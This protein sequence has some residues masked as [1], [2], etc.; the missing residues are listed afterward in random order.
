M[1]QKHRY[2]KENNEALAVASKD[3]GLE[4]NA[5]KTKYMVMFRDQKVGQYHNIKTD[6]KALE[7]WGSSN[8][9]EQPQGIK[10]PFRRKLRAE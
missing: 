6:N 1:G 3:I 2:H 7:A 8:I 4:V 5:E 10:I 9:W